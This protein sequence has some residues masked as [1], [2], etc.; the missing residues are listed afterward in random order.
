MERD[1][2]QDRFKGCLLGLACGDA[3]GATVEFKPRGMF[4]PV[5]D[6]VDG[7]P[8][9]LKPGEW[10]DDTSMALCLASSLAELRRFDPKDQM[11]RY[12]RWRRRTGHACER[13]VWS[14]I[15]ETVF[16]NNGAKTVSG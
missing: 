1:D 8:F 11:Q 15:R 9:R 4:A 6:M 2:L 5:M 16:Q 3:V 13:I 12:L 7:E 10:T 14:Y